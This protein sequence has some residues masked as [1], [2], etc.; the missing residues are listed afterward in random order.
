MQSSIVTHL[1][2]L[3]AWRERVAGAV[4]D[5]ARL[6]DDHALAD[7]ADLAAISALRTRLLSD[8]LVLAFVAEFSRGKSELINAIFFAD[9][10]RRMLPATPG[11]TTMCPVELFSDSA[12]A[13]RLSLLPIETRLQGVALSEL[14]GRDEAWLHRPLPQ[15]DPDA[16]ADAL[17]AVTQ[18]RRVSVDLA[19]QLGLW[20][21]TE[22]ADN[23]PS[24]SDG[25]V[26]V[27]AW[28][29]ALIN[30]PHPLLQRG[31]VVIDTPGLNAIGAEPELTLGLLPSAHA[32]VFVLA[33]D[34][35]VTRSDLA[36][37]RDCLAGRALER[38]VVLNKIDALADPL[39][40]PAEVE[41]Q[42]EHQCEQT[43]ATLDVPPWRVF[44][45][46][47]R[48]AL[49]ARVAGDARALEASRLPALE[50]ALGEELLPR[51]REL[52][53]QAAGT[54]I[55]QLR[56]AASRRLAERRRHNAEQMLELRGLRGKSSAKVRLMLQRLAA[57][58]ADFERCTGRLAALSSVHAR[59]L[60]ALLA[61]LSSDALRAEVATM[62]ASIRGGPFQ[63]GARKAFDALCGRL[64]HT[65]TG[66]AAQA[67]EM[68]QM[69]DGSFQ[70]LNTEFGFAFALDPAPKLPVYADD[71]D[72]IAQSY[73]RYLS[74]TQAWR[75]AT[76][77]FAEQFR[78]MLVAKLRVVF[79]SA[80][81]DV[82]LWS[83]A[84]SGQIDTQLRERRRG[85]KR[86][87]EALLRIQ[88]AAGDLEQRI[89]EVETTDQRLAALQAE[90]DRAAAQ[91][92][93]SARGG[94]IAAS[95][96]AEQVDT[97]VDADVDAARRTAA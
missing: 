96:A 10:G 95:R 69:L 93:A 47:A 9:A 62:Q 81:G 42:I 26:E 7:H 38:F 29:H 75:M 54:A 92:N 77:G 5:F 48:N 82:E 83:K 14:R 18:T 32:T 55:E 74:L 1:D 8:K 36:I 37:W 30:H 58:S 43:A 39:L 57:E 79:E 78:R 86:R 61:A 94:Q 22:S 88:S 2:T 67:D 21:D 24:G 72:R 68:R 50:A 87:E 20:S 34:S 45:L 65:L 56:C 12:A 27:P 90:L 33:A 17:T 73:G 89:S 15:G 49:T 80:A 13:P 31:L 85:Y 28:R 76:P 66:A 97:G 35:G 41:A 44:P 52:L 91:A 6:A 11:R 59:L 51:Q 53:R 60:R 16:L 40:K 84:A 64:R 3:A 23:P 4:L 46:S 63:I 19:R 25:T 70:Q 71:L